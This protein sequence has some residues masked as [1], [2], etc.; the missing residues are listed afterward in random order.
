MMASEL[1]RYGI[2]VRIVDESPGIDPHVRAN[3][4]HSRTLEIFRTL[5]IDDEVTRGSIAEHGIRI[6][7]QGSLAG[8]LRHAPVE[9]PFPYGMSQS[10]ATT[11][12]VLEA[13][14]R[15]LGV[16]VERSVALRN[17]DPQSDRVVATIEHSGGRSETFETPWLVGC[18]GAHSAVRHLTGCAFPGETDPYPYLL[19]D[20]VVD[21]PLN[22]HEGYV[23][24]HDDGD[25][26]I[27]S[28]L[29]GQRRL[30]C[31]TAPPGHPAEKPPTLGDLQRMLDVRGVSGLR[32][33]DP[34]W[35]AYFRIHYRLAPHYRQGRT[36]LAGDAAHVH[37]LMAGQGMNT[38]IQDAYNLAWKLALVMKGVA[39]QWWL[40]S[41][42][43]ERRLV[44]AQVV[45]M[46]QKMT[47]TLEAFPGLSA[48]DRERLLGHM[49]VPESDRIAAA[50]ELQELDLDYAESPLCEDGEGFTRGP[51]AG[52]GAPNVDGLSIDGRPTSVFQVLGTPGY[53]LFA[54]IGDLDPADAFQATAALSVYPWVEPYLVTTRSPAARAGVAALLDPDGSMHARYEAQVPTVYLVRPDGYVAFRQRGLDGVQH[55]L[56]RIT[57]E[58]APASLSGARH[59]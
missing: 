10:Q 11:E 30:V 43:A 14:L 52:E 5:G 29:P 4:L 12:A 32:V 48:K 25:Y 7:A 28:T 8:E 27:F 44:G 40:D 13:H 54:F 41:Y 24:L 53:H 46:T 23:F 51:S 36:F 19:G 33:S 38:G 39:P 37:S 16:R 45:T 35:L 55:H 21:G 9:S 47:E 56:S 42:D 31:A 18:D 15:K 50:R 49:F 2:P 6:Y 17:L 22:E 1:A 57:S 34:R 59:P 20:V 3:L 26:F 58:N